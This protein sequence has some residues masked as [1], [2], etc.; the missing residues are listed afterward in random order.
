MIFDFC[1][2]LLLKI[3]YCFILSL[4]PFW[5]SKKI[6]KNIYSIANPQ[7]FVNKAQPE[8]QTQPG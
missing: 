2:K 1:R 4:S 5:E 6:F 8:N 7:S 3:V